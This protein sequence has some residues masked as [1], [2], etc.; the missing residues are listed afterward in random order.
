LWQ[1][2]IYFPVLVFCAKKNLATQVFS[3][4]VDVLS[5]GNLDVDI[6]TSRRHGALSS[7]LWIGV[8]TSAKREDGL[9]AAA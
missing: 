5:V 7:T 8:G 1:F 3:H 6:V 2:G 9:L 4:S